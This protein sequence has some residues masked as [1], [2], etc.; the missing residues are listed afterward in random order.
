MYLY[1]YLYSLF[2]FVFVYGRSGGDRPTTT[3][4]QVTTTVQPGIVSVSVFVFVF[5]F[6]FVCGS[7][8]DISTTSHAGEVI[9]VT[10]VIN[11]QQG[12]GSLFVYNHLPLSYLIL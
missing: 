8:W 12:A 11:I 1:F 2:V 4:G 6:A 9:E 7:G 3:P 5:V 10:S